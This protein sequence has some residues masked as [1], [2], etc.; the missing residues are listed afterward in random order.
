MIRIT[1]VA[2]KRGSSVVPTRVS[3]TRV[4]TL[5][6]YNHYYLTPQ[7][8]YIFFQFYRLFSCSGLLRFSKKPDQV[9]TGKITKDHENKVSFTKDHDNKVSF[10]KD[11]LNWIKKLPALIWHGLVHTWLGFKMLWLNSRSS[12]AILF[13]KMTG[14]KIEYREQ[15]L[16]TRTGSDLLKLIPFSF[17]I[18]VPFAE[19]LLPIA[20]HLFPKLL[21]STFETEEQ[22]EKTLKDM[23]EIRMRI[24]KEIK[25]LSK[26]LFDPSLNENMD[27][28]EFMTKLQSDSDVSNEQLIKFAQ[29]FKDKITM[30]NLKKSQIQVM[31][32]YLHMPHSG[33]TQILKMQLQN[34]IVKI[35]NEDEMLRGKLHEEELIELQQ[36]CLE[37]GISSRGTRRTLEKHLEDW[38]N[39]SVNHKVPTILLILSWAF[40]KEKLDE[41]TFDRVKE[42]EKEKE[43]E[44]QQQN[45]QETENKK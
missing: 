25:T 5:K 21:P 34:R 23:Q 29:N 42:I 22:K 33:P 12:V 19:F 15:R 26:S 41:T 30:D 36:A 16:L 28:Q 20:L 13:R 27:F 2:T 8:C 1:Q 31:C 44:N 4:V 17:F 43:K 7:K 39:L 45:S 40:R 32:R 38:L 6:A 18:I 3:P 11:P 10:T 14:Q 9:F 37:R 24:S 35:I